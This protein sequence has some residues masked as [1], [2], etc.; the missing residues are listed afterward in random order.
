MANIGRGCGSD[1]DDGAAQYAKAE[2]KAYYAK[3][4]K[5]AANAASRAAPTTPEAITRDEETKNKAFRMKN[6]LKTL[7]DAAEEIKELEEQQ[8]SSADEET[9]HELLGMAMKLQAQLRETNKKPAPRTW[10]QE[11]PEYSSQELV[12]KDLSSDIPL[13]RLVMLMG[14]GNAVRDV[15]FKDHYTFV[16][17]HNASV[18][19]EQYET[20]METLAKDKWSATSVSRARFRGDLHMHEIDSGIEK[21]RYKPFDPKKV[22]KDW[23][24]QSRGS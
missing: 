20:V 7:Q 14:G 9:A 22:Y 18:C 11:H 3:A 4:G 12:L 21:P 15:R 24:S 16:A 19:T 1:P 2:G 6:L 5:N 17:F 13:E 23:G 8:D 10:T